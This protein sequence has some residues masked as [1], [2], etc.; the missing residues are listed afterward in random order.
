MEEMDIQL[1]TDY[2]MESA[3]NDIFTSLEQALQ[4][5]TEGDVRDILA[6]IDTV[7]WIE[8][9]RILKGQPFSFKDRDYL[10]EIAHQSACRHENQRNPVL[11]N[12]LFQEHHILCRCLDWK[13]G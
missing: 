7:S 11:R 12:A 4:S 13:C 2:E 8:S 3:N 6:D 9:R 10:S 5:L 1:S